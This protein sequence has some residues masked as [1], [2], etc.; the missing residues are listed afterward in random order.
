MLEERKKGKKEG[1]EGSQKVDHTPN[2]KEK[3]RERG[4]IIRHRANGRI[5]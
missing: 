2:I 5:H 1:R 3:E 4:N